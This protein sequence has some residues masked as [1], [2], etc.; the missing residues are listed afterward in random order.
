M[1]SIHN[2]AEA[3]LDVADG[4]IRAAFQT[5]SS[6]IEVMRQN[7][8]IQPHGWLVA[9]LDDE[10]AGLV[11]ATNYGPFAYIGMM[12]VVPTAQRRGVGRALLSYQL[13]RLAEERCSTVLLDA[14][15]SGAP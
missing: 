2:L 1:L 10:P 12:S 7:L 11:G 5:S 13:D 8:A 9:T 4:I 3:D 6:R 14:S 15:K